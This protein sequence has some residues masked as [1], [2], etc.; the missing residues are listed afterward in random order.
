MHEDL[1]PHTCGANMRRLKPI[2]SQKF[3][4]ITYIRA[5]ASEG[6]SRP[7]MDFENFSNK[8]LFSQFRVGKIKFHHFG[9]RNRKI[10]EK[11]P[12]GTHWK[13]SSRRPCIWALAF[14][15]SRHIYV[16]VCLHAHP[17]RGESHIQRH[18]NCE[19]VTKDTR[20][21][22]KWLFITQYKA[23]VSL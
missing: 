18:A 10:L 6:G 15:Y 17:V 13:K 19:V 21:T 1:H 12:N 3:T 22:Q 9:P 8:K 23:D 11:F 14:A 4:Y 16:G 7:P 20:I 5:W 2:S